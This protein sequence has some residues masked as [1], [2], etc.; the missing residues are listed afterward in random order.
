RAYYPGLGYGTT[1]PN[2][3]NIKKTLC[4][5]GRKRR[6]SQAINLAFKIFHEGSSTELRQK[7]TSHP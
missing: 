2:S 6:L 1:W 5:D 4:E 3:D 7:S